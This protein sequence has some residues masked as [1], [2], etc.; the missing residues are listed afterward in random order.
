M[1]RRIVDVALEGIILLVGYSLMGAC[2]GFVGCSEEE[3][4]SVDR[5]WVVSVLIDDET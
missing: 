5:R 2:D 1:G 3:Y 4:R